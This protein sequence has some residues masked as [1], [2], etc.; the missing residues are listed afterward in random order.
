MNKICKNANPDCKLFFF[1]FAYNED[2]TKGFVKEAY[3][4]AAG[5]KIMRK[6]SLPAVIELVKAGAMKVDRI[7]CHGPASEL[8]QLKGELGANTIY[9]YSAPGGFM[10]RRC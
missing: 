4:S 2:G 3:D 1:S 6:R 7:E 5:L 8:D 10:N 9:F